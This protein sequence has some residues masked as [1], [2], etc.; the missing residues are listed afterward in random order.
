MPMVTGGGG[1]GRLTAPRPST[2][3]HRAEHNKTGHQASPA[4]SKG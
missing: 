4:Y 2:L 3:R 1:A